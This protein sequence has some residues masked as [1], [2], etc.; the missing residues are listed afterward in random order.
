VLDKSGRSL[1]VRQNNENFEIQDVK[2]SFAV[3]KGKWFYCIHSTLKLDKEIKANHC[4]RDRLI[5]FKTIALSRWHVAIPRAELG[6]E[7][8][9]KP[10]AWMLS[11]PTKT[12]ILNVWN[13]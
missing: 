13:E 9:K 5:G 2:H 3:V 6:G 12:E 11:Q 7:P 8:I 4:R 10:I 1:E